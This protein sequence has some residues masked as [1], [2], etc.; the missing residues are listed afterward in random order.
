[1]TFTLRRMLIGFAVLWA[2]APA[3]LAV[4]PPY[5]SYSSE[6]TGVKEND[7]AQRYSNDEVMQALKENTKLLQELLQRL[8]TLQISSAALQ[9]TR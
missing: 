1:M 6:N 2:L 3:A 4:M 9:T 5:T 7:K 8:R